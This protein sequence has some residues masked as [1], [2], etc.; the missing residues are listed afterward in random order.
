MLRLIGVKF[1]QHLIK[2]VKAL[3]YASFYKSK[4]Q[5]FGSFPES[6]HHG[7]GYFYKSKYQDFGNLD[8]AI[9]WKLKHII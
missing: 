8:E 9:F 6:K 7:F 5:D 1:N 2:Y 3:I 4:H